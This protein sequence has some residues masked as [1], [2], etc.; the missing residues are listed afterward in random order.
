MLPNFMQCPGALSR[1]SGGM[2][3]Y[4]GPY[5][6]QP[7]SQASGEMSGYC[8]LNQSQT[9]L[10]TQEPMTAYHSL[11]QRH[12]VSPTLEQMPDYCSQHE[13]QTWLQG[14]EQMAAYRSP[15]ETQLMLQTLEQTLELHSP[16]QTQP[17]SRAPARMPDYPSPYQ[18]DPPMT[19]PGINHQL[20][21]LTSLSPEDSTTFQGARSHQKCRKTMSP[22]TENDEEYLQSGNKSVP[23][24]KRN[25]RKRNP[26]TLS[27]HAPAQS[28]Q[29]PDLGKR[30]R[31]ASGQKVSK[32]RQLKAKLGNTMGSDHRARE[33]VL[34]A[35]GT[36]FGWVYD[37]WSTL[38]RHPPIR[39]AKTDPSLEPAVYHTDVRE[40]LILLDAQ[41]PGAPG[42]SPRP[43]CLR[44]ELMR[45]VWER[46]MS[47]NYTS[48]S[49]VTQ[50]WTSD[51][52]SIRDL[53]GRQVCLM[54]SP[55]ADWTHNPK[56]EFLTHEGLFILDENNR[57]IKDFPGAPLALSNKAPAHLLE[58]L[59]RT[60][61]MTIPE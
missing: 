12:L 8:S 43:T 39:I 47:L 3:E 23:S 44:L 20:P 26:A 25:R 54:R 17:I 22:S 15:H 40:K 51:P 30:S 27:S 56:T 42:E 61:G 9:T 2:P 38:V 24:K 10:H 16:Y 1:T 4:C 11:Y 48:Y 59:R 28:L 50:D 33:N 21:S 57:P 35:N 6:M 53:K 18:R 34:W 52:A 29:Q 55:P 36:M 5:Q 31:A 19:D 14:Q 37:E 60:F 46:G 58:G 7:M 32:F 45:I 49:P 13:T 41:Q